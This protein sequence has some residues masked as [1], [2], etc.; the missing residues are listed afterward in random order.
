MNNAKVFGSYE[1]D[2]NAFRSDSEFPNRRFL[3]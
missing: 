2:K 1:K 3:A